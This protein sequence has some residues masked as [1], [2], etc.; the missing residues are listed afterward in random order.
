MAKIIHKIKDPG[1]SITH[2]IGA[3]LSFIASIFL[4]ARACTYYGIVH[5]VSISVFCLSLVL[6]YTASTLYHTL[7]FSDKTNKRLRK[8]DH[9]MIYILIAGTYTPICV[10]T[11]KGPVGYAMLIIIWIMALAGCFIT[12]FV[13]NPIKW[14][15][16][17]VYIA[18]GWTCIL[19]FKFLLESLSLIGFLFLL[20]G[21]ILYTIGGVIYALK[22]PLFDSIHPHFGAH[23]I[24]HL[25]V[26]AGS[27]FHVAFMFVSIVAIP[28]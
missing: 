9:T 24:F 13:K 15:S 26:M 28:S 16:S 12:L 11:L 3:V 14:I 17:L 20:I 2:F 23:E 22:L 8:F 4:I 18:M 5:I 7:D 1:S 25:F 10:T 6:L 21:G 27:A 19:A